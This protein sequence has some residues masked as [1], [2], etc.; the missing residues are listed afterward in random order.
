MPVRRQ[1][2]LAF[3]AAL[4]VC[5][6]AFAW[7]SFDVRTT[8]YRTAWRSH[9]PVGEII[10]AFRV[11]QVIP[12]GLVRIRPPARKSVHW[13]GPHSL[14][15]LA[16]PNCFSIRFATYK[17]QNEGSIVVSWQQGS[18]EQSWRVA[19]AGLV[20]NRYVDFCPRDGIDTGKP[21]LV[22]LEGIDGRPGRAATAWLTKSRL[23]P[24]T[25]AGKHIGNRSLALQLV[26]L[27]HVTPKDISSLGR[28]AFLLSCLCSLGIAL[29]AFAAAGRSLART[30][31]SS[32]D[33]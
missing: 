13:H 33:G 14:R 5:G 6:M 18:A 15:T 27:H 7:R 4:L 1:L 12:A 32:S 9:K 10:G 22:T 23:A 16:E 17:R 20:D 19:V 11:T 24:A 25:V 21:S 8:A 28:G 3:A 30:A 26:Y 2:F 31:S 29:L